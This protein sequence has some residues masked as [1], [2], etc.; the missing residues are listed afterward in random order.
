MSAR[1][2]A[3]KSFTTSRS[4]SQPGNRMKALGEHGLHGSRV[5]L[6][7]LTRVRQ[8]FGWADCPQLPPPSAGRCDAKIKKLGKFPCRSPTRGSGFPQ[9]MTETRRQKPSAMPAS[10]PM[11]RHS[12]HSLSSPWR[13]GAAPTKRR[14]PAGWRCL[15]NARR[16]DV[17]Q[18]K[19]VGA[20]VAGPAN[21]AERD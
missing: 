1:P 7:A 13:R 2:A 16:N 6:E 11:G 14:S 20:P 4:V 15:R 10:A 5:S 12:T 18:L 17:S 9:D 19:P 8:F 3:R 21:L